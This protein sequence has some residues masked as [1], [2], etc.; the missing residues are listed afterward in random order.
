MAAAFS[1]DPH[2]IPQYGADA[3]ADELTGAAGQPFRL[4]FHLGPAIG[5]ELAGGT[6]ELDW[7][8]AGRPRTASLTLAPEL[9]WTAHRGETDPPLG[10][11]SPGFGRLQPATT[12]VG[13]STGTGALASTAPTVLCTLIR[14]HP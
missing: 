5:V 9:V 6:A 11:Y 13:T 10:W 12:L 8:H 1:W 3:D 2:P 14:F 7:R 4:A